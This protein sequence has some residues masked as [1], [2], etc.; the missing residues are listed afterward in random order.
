[1]IKRLQEIAL[2]AG[3]RIGSDMYNKDYSDFTGFLKD[4]MPINDVDIC[5]ANMLINGTRYNGEKA[6][7]NKGISAASLGM[8]YLVVYPILGYL[9][10]QI[11]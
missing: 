6:T 1:M 2:D 8:K 5:Q 4:F 7:R 10:S 9:I 3:K 11:Q